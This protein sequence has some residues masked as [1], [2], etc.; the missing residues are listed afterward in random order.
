MRIGEMT[1]TLWSHGELLGESALDYVRVFPKLRTGDLEVTTRGLTLIGRLTQTREDSYRSARRVTHT[2]AGAS[3]EF[4]KSFFADAAAFNDQYNAL[5]LELRSS[6]GTV[7]PTEDIHITDVEALLSRDSELEDQWD[8]D[9]LD[10]GPD[11][12]ADAAA[13][14]ML[15]A[16]E[17]DHPAWLSE[18]PERPP[19]R[20]Q[21]AVMLVDEWAIP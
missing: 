14:E 7:I 2:D 8:D 6:D 10:D 3:E 19:A 11:P 20:F 5:S 1:Y 18:G 13:A 21:I 9:E 15:A 16:W 12:D 4:E 17:E